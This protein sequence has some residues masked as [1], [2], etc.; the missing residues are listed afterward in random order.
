M[1]RNTIA[2]NNHALDDRR[3][4]DCIMTYGPAWTTRSIAR[5]RAVLT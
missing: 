2:R 3:Y 5:A 1:I 4:E